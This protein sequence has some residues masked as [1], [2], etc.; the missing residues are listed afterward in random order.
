[1]FAGRLDDGLAGLVERS[2]D[3][4][5]G[6]GVG[7][8]DESLQL[9]WQQSV[10]KRGISR[11]ILFHL[12]NLRTV[13]AHNLWENLFYFLSKHLFSCRIFYKWWL[14][15]LGSCSLSTVST[16]NKLVLRFL[17][18]SGR[19]CP[20]WCC[21]GLRVRVSSSSAACGPCGAGRSSAP[22]SPLDSAAQSPDWGRNP[23][24]VS[25][26]SPA[27]RPDT[28]HWPDDLQG[29]TFNY[30]SRA[31]MTPERGRNSLH[32]IHIF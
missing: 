13:S 17:R 29:T 8:L 27:S 3:P 19:R 10:Q 20:R 28:R 21:S 31:Q 25:A 22:R 11:W 12:S 5:V 6:S 18:R 14:L 4:V 15:L 26:G 24:S 2:V 1:M 16:I 23:P 30:Y 7:R 32:F 9:Q